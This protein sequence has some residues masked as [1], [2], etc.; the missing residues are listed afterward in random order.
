[1]N[2]S[3][4][5]SD[6]H[7]YYSLYEQ[8][9]KII[10]ATDKVYFLGDAGDRGP[11]GWKLIKDILDNPQWEYIYGNH[12][13]MLVRRFFY[14]DALD[15]IYNHGY[16]TWEAL[17]KDEKEFGSD[18]VID[19]LKRLDSSKLFDEY[20]RDDGK[21]I[22]LNHSGCLDM[23][24]SIEYN[25]WDRSSFGIIP[26]DYLVV[27]GHTPISSVARYLE[28]LKEFNSGRWLPTEEDDEEV[29]DDFDGDVKDGEHPY[30][31]CGGRKVDI[32]PTTAFTGNGIL[33]DLDTFDYKMLKVTEPTF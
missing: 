5:C 14:G 32:D 26:E 21:R 12:D 22:L 3:Y 24:R 28:E 10:D 7:G 2:K 9:N 16:P 11:Y 30:F 33:L 4:A 13:L 23:K 27:H 19:Y 25:V 18:Y 8:I 29:S 1:M 31:Y 20:C 17:K 6:F 15:H